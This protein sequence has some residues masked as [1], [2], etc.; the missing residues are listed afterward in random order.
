MK[1]NLQ[2]YLFISL[3]FISGIAF[4][5]SCGNETGTGGKVVLQN[6][7]QAAQTVIHAIEVVFDNSSTN[8]SSDSVQE[9]IVEVN[10][11]V[12]AL[13]G[14]VH[15]AKSCP[16]GMTNVY[17]QFCMENN[18]HPN[19]T[20]PLA[21]TAC[22]QAE[23][24]L[25]E[26]MEWYLTCINN[27]SFPDVINMINTSWEWSGLIQSNSGNSALAILVGGNGICANVTH[28]AN[29]ASLRPYRCCLTL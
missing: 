20:L 28:D 5:V 2:K 17:N 23:R 12:D 19:T 9:A 29:H 14:E 16:S 21:A 3:G 22:G 25:C 18:E 8:L 10:S 6:L 11:K 24:R 4:V 26:P 15:A 13:G 7:A 27:P 1:K